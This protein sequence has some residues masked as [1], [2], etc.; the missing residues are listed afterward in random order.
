M[1][2][3]G[4]AFACLTSATVLGI[5]STSAAWADPPDPVTYRSAAI[6]D[7]YDANNNS[8]IELG[9]TTADGKRLTTAQR[10]DLLGYDANCNKVITF[11]EVYAVEKLSA[12]ARGAAKVG[13]RVK[14]A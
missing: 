7:K 6:I 5:L 4:I 8:T 2:I 10:T 3:L 11:S 9:T 1:R 12:V 13:N 14:C